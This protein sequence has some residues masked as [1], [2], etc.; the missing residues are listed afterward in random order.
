MVTLTVQI[1]VLKRQLPRCTRDHHAPE[2]LSAPTGDVGATEEAVDSDTL[3][4]LVQPAFYLRQELP[5]TS[6]AALH[7]GRGV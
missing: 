3:H 7:D 4:C 1:S 2:N 5:S 6:S